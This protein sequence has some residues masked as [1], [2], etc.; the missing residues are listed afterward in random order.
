MSL[1]NVFNLHGFCDYIKILKNNANWFAHAWFW[2]WV[3]G[4]E[5]GEYIVLWL[6]IDDGDCNI[7]ILFLWMLDGRF[8]SVETLFSAL[9]HEG[10]EWLDE[11]V[12]LQ[13]SQT[14]SQEYPWVAAWRFGLRFGRYWILL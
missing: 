4:T 12:L 1:E 10:C 3:V 14:L 5:G 8:D 6:E 11:D 9:Y 7:A 2:K 13:S